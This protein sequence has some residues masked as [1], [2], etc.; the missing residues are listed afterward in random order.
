METPKK[1]PQITGDPNIDTKKHNKIQQ[2]ED[3]RSVETT[4]YLPGA[5]LDK[6]SLALLTVAWNP[7]LEALFQPVLSSAN[8]PLKGY[9]KTLPGYEMNVNISQFKTNLHS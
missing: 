8:D 5:R 3:P 7:S 9:C 4:M 1:V 2:K 6:C